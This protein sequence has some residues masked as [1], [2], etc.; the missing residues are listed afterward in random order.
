MVAHIAPPLE[1][2][3]ARHEVESLLEPVRHFWLLRPDA[4]VFE[5]VFFKTTVDHPRCEVDVFGYGTSPG[6][7]AP[8]GFGN[9]AYLAAAA[10]IDELSLPSIHVRPRTLTSRLQALLE[11][12]LRIDGSD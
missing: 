11:P 9:G 12:K 3:L 4:L 5:Y 10:E 6:A 1:G 7:G 8:Y 2:H